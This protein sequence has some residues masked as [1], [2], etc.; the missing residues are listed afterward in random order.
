MRILHLTN[1]VGEHK[2]GGLHEVVSNLYRCQ[3][4]NSHEPHVWY[5]GNEEDA[6]SFKT[7]ENVTALSTFGK[8]KYGIVK[9]LFRPVPCVINEFEV[10]HQHGIWMPIS[11]Y[12]KKLRKNGLKCVIQ[13]HGYLLEHSF[14]ISKFKKSIAFQL[15]EK[16][17]LISA[18]V[19]VACAKH[20]AIVLKEFFPK[21]EVAI[22]PN[23]ISDDFFNKPLKNIYKKS[24]KKR[25]LFLGQIIPIKGIERVLI[26]INEI[27]LKSFSEWEFI[28]AGYYDQGYK[29]SL[30]EIIKTNKMDNF[31]KFVDPVNGEDKV[32]LYDSCH[33]FILPSFNENFGIVVLEAL[34]RGL[35]V[36][37]TMGTP[38][39]EL[40][41]NECGFWV[42][43]NEN[44][45]QSALN[46]ILEMSINDLKKMGMKGRNLVEKKYLWSKTSLDFLSL[47]EWLLNKRSKPSCI[48]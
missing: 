12:S 40:V 7:D 26:A 13:P 21:Q 39:N 9:N 45:I 38:W 11:I 47:Y 6:I 17:N 22:I 19:L 8:L 42:G 37:A 5:P 24:K 32:D 29:K 28:I 46:K 18:D 31:V 16:S 25:L 48:I 43:N 33:I 1:I 2:G 3:K 14:K 34:S 10:L 30:T 23:G 36:I 44:G 35:P 27:G 20:E 4:L 15:Y 41:N